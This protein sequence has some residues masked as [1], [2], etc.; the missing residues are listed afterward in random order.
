[1]GSRLVRLLTRAPAKCQ[2]PPKISFPNC[3]FDNISNDLV[4]DAKTEHTQHLD[5]QASDQHTYHISMQYQRPY[6]LLFLLTLVHSLLS[7]SQGASLHG[8]PGPG[9]KGHQPGAHQANGEKQQT[10]RLQPPGK[11]TWAPGPRTGGGRERSPHSAQ[12]M[13]LSLTPGWGRG[14]SLLK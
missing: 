8:P 11:E 14:R 1:M 9:L 13:A 10:L 4:T 3:F 7:I 2:N 5:R 12:A 6:Y